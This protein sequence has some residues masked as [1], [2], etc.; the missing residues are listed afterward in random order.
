MKYLGNRST[1]LRQTHIRK[2]CLVPARTTVKVKVNFGG[3]RAAS[4]VRK[5][6]FALVFQH[7]KNERR[8][9]DST[10]DSIKTQTFDPSILILSSCIQARKEGVYF[11][12]I[13]TVA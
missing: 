10:C 4:C 2:T 1:D 8:L 11:A 12:T 13:S 6:I 3:L 5:N 7:F 9:Y